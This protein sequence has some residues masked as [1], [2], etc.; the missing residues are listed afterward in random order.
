MP[1]PRQLELLRQV[2][3]LA[4]LP[5]SLLAELADQLTPYSAPQG[6]RILRMGEVSHCM[7]VIESGRVRVHKDEL[8]LAE[9]TEGDIFGE[10]SLIDSEPRSASVSA[11]TDVVLH[12]LSRQD[13]FAV[14]AADSRLFEGILR[15]L[16]GRMRQMASSQIHELER[17]E[18]M[19]QVLV[20]QRTAELRLANES[21][22]H[23]NEEILLRQAALENA[24]QELKATN[25]QL[26]QRTAELNEQKKY[27]EK[28]NAL[29]EENNLLLR[30]SL[31]TI[32]R[33]QEHMIQSEKM[34]A[35]GM[36]APVVAHEIN[37]PTGAVKAAVENMQQMLPQLFAALAACLDRV[38]GHRQAEIYALIDHLTAHNEP[39]SS[40]EERRLIREL[41]RL[42][43]DAGFPQAEDFAQRLV[44]A[45]VVEKHDELLPWLTDIDTA[46]VVLELAIEMGRIRRQLLTVDQAADR[47]RRIV[48]SLTNYVHRRPESS[49]P[50]STD[51]A[52]NVDIVLS[53]Y[54]YYFR[55][56]I[57]LSR[58]YA[59]VPLVPGFPENLIQVWTNILM[60][61]LHAFKSNPP[62]RRA[63][64]QIMI[65]SQDEWVAVRI[66]NNGPPIPEAIR[67]RIFEP[68]FTTKAKE[69]GTGL[70]LSI[71]L[72]IIE[73]HGGRIEVQSDDDWTTFS[74]LLP[75]AG[76]PAV[77]Q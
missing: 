1:R 69:E 42:L 6:L 13:F 30:Q 3:F 54:E 15:Q 64:I 46:I 47:V 11:L 57:E 2:V 22:S 65:E 18:E 9:L 67:A 70:G 10:F 35:L 34:A 52:A 50:T 33:Q 23:A 58:H 37:T 45:G 73:Q 16:V 21:L 24:Y 26:N 74:V 27:I 19:L 39:I 32:Q 5:E 76:P 53:L 66:R 4:D 68:L 72:K 28:N 25:E 60:N 62:D 41:E 55:Q 61:A 7:Y 77:E 43:A 48:T 59:N 51:L 49:K 29:L 44:R 14:L 71:T 8:T 56:G 40:R 31:D 63:I 20:D 36:L 12:R 17:R 75:V 38:G